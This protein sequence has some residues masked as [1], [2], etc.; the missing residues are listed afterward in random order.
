MV[1]RTLVVLRYLTVFSVKSLVGLRERP[2]GRG[3]L[4]LKDGTTLKE[5]GD[6]FSTVSGTPSVRVRL[7]RR[8]RTTPCTRK[9]RGERRRS[10]GARLRLR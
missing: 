10:G 6:G 3:P 5:E 1:K 2:V 8:R 4:R 9:I 7:C